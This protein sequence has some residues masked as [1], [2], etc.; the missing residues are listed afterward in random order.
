MLLV[1]VRINDYFPKCYEF[2]SVI[3]MRC[4]FCEVGMNL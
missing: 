2:V 1:I 3:Q 4:A